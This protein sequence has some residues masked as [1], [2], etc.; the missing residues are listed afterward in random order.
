M[1]IKPAPFG[2]K[3]IRNYS[4]VIGFARARIKKYEA[5]QIQFQEGLPLFFR[6]DILSSQDWRRLDD[7]LS[8][9]F[10]EID[11]ADMEAR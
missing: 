1:E 6:Q 8:R 2:R 4:E 9:L 3:I 7:V 11:P 5:L 10:P